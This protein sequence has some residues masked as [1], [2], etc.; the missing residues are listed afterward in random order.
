MVWTR[1]KKKRKGS[2]K[3]EGKRAKLYFA[4]RKSG[5]LRNNSRVAG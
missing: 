4:M 3:R 1:K 2:K 5:A